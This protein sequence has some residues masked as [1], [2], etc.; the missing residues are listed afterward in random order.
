MHDPIQ[1]WPFGEAP[2]ELQA[3]SP[4]GGDE[5]WLAVLPASYDPGVNVAP[6]NISLP[7]WMDDGSPFGCCSVSRH[8]L[9]DGR[10]V[11]I[12]AHA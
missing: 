8:R 12:G 7:L 9:A 1:V 4:H 10:L 2:P 5:D 6:D 11:A 3:L